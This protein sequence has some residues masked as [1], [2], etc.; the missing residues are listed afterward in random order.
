MAPQISQRA[1]MRRDDICIYVSPANRVRLEA[2]ITDRNS[3]SKAVWRARIVL[4]TADGLGTSAI[5]K[6]TGKSKPCV[7]RWQERYIEEGV[8]GL[9]RDK[10][11][12][13][14][15]KPLSATVKRKVLA[16]T[17]S[18]M[19]PNSTHWSV[20]SMATAV[21][22]SHTSVQRIWAEAGLKPHLVRR[23][24]I[25]NDP[26]FEE[27]VTDVVGLYL[28]PP[29]RALVL[30]VDEKSQI[31]ALDRT[32]P[33]LP[34]KKGRAATMTHDYKRHG[35]TTLFAA[36]DV[37]SGLVIGECQPRHRAKEFI[38]FLKRIDRCVQKHLDVH[39][40]L[41]NYGTHKT[42]EVKAWLAKHRRFKLHFT[43]TS[44]SWLNLVER[45]FAEITTKRI[46]RGI[47]RS[48]AELEDAIHDYLDHH[49]A[50]PKP[51]VWTKSAE[52]IMEKERRA[53]DRLEAINA[54]YQA[55]ES[56]H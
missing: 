49:N 39:L 53:L 26:Q 24:K 40:V 27:K 30:C 55:S 50:D 15:K 38:R 19:P 28:N 37:K 12:P 18:E 54:G 7:W 46:R 25:S 22:I 48:V 2:I 13:P 17:G 6:R 3:P 41:D 23:F 5:M 10:T 33:G 29:D 47:F 21:G 36:L 35:T 42:P 1:M 11:R 31:Q 56:E 44:A 9:L 16:K 14:G 4:A 32:Q 45:F 51:F 52:V 8:E 43:P 34:L 20:R